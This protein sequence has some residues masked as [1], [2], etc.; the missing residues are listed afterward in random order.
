[1]NSIKTLTL[2]LLLSVTQLIHAQIVGE[3][4]IGVRAG[5]SGGPW[6]PSY[7]YVLNHNTAVEGFLGYTPKGTGVYTVDGED[8]RAGSWLLG[9][10][11][12]P[13]IHTGDRHN[14]SNFYADLGLRAR[15][16]NHR[17]KGEVA[18]QDGGIITPEVYV[19]AGGLFELS[20]DFEI[21]ATFGMKYYNKSGNIY[22]PA[23]EAGAGFRIRLN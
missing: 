10:C 5:V 16:H 6:G 15:L 19:G 17:I 7:R 21:F 2:L 13:F 8:V 23:V 3:Q 9:V 4:A 22:G 20:D 12:Q 18:N 14:G 1:M 11:Y